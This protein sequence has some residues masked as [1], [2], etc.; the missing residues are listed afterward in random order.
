MEQ[1]API[2][3]GH[4]CDVDHR[5]V[6]NIGERANFDVVGLGSHDDL[7]P[8]G[9]ALVQADIAIQF[10][11]IGQPDWAVG[12]WP[13]LWHRRL[14]SGLQGPCLTV[15]RQRLSLKRG[16]Y[17]CHHTLFGLLLRIDR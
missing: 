12:K 14:S 10:G 8:H 11:A 1:Y 6:L 9:D 5:E 16:H 7:G 17:G 4:I 15:Y 13:L 3:V 2:L